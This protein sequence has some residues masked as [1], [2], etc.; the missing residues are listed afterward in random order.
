MSRVGNQKLGNS[1]LNI[2]VAEGE[3]MVEC[4]IAA[5][6]ADGYAVTGKK[7][8]GLRAAGAVAAAVNNAAGTDGDVMVRVDRGT[9]V[10]GNDGS[11]K[12]TDI[13]KPCYIAGPDS[14]TITATGSS[15]AGIIIAVDDDGV[16]VDMT[17]G[18]IPIEVTKEEPTQ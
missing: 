4:T 18:M 15:E 12:N 10:W 16:T 9:F 17:R 7:M 5:I 6:N 2:P 11:I 3:K 1:I 8:E 13:L 14:V